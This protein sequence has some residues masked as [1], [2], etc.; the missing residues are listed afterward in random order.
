MMSTCAPLFDNAPEYR[1]PID[2]KISGTIPPWLD[3]SLYRTGP[4]TTRIATNADPS[5]T[6]NVQH[7]FD[8]L[9]MHHRFEVSS[10]GQR[11][12]YRCHKGS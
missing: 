10:G 11:V 3:G 5:K 1:D 8:G 12:S 2:L 9:S 6:V 4:G 7:L